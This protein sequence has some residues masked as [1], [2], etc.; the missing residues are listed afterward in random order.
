MEERLQK[1]LSRCGLCSRRT[2]EEWIGQG[3]VTVNGRR[4]LLGQSAD[5]DRDAVEV[6]GKPVEPPDH[7]YLM[8]N[9]PRGYVT[10]AR[11]EKGRRTVL[12]LL[13]DVP[14]RVYPVGRLDMDS[15]GLLLLTND[16]ALTQQLTHPSHHVGKEYLLRLKTP[17]ED[18]AAGLCRPMVLDGRPLAPVR[19]RLVGQKGEESLVLLTIYEGRNRQIRRMC[20]LQGYQLRRLR[21]V[22]VGRLRLDKLPPGQW[23]YLTPSEVAYLRSLGP[24]KSGTMG[25]RE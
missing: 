12:D 22:A 4:A 3:R 15:E 19:A 10:T 7:L 1:I 11:D 20:Q 24:A 14:G 8:L 16:G 13:E 2:A 23:R 21:R 17:A 5:L 18:P 9:K 25:V 6:D